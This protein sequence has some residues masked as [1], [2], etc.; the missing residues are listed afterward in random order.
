MAEDVAAPAPGAQPASPEAVAAA[1]GLVIVAVWK[2]ALV[3]LAL[4]ALLVSTVVAA[5][6]DLG[7]LNNVV[8]VGIAMLKA[9]LVMLF[10]MHVRWS[11]RLIGLAAAAGFL[12][13]LYLLSGTMTDY[14]T[15]GLLS[16]PDK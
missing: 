7:A 4:L 5:F 12:W 15:R 10:F 13:L 14:V 9:G 6:F 2:Y 11:S 16:L 8:A 3:Y 1:E